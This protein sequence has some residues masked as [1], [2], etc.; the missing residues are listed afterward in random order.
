MLTANDIIHPPITYPLHTEKEIKECNAFVKWFVATYPKGFQV[1][2]VRSY[3]V[4]HKI[5]PLPASV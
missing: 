4:I 2:V 5:E 3:G 1:I